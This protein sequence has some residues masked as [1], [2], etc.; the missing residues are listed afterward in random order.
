[1]SSIDL[2]MEQ[3]LLESNTSLFLR[4]LFI[5][6][7]LRN[8]EYRTSFYKCPKRES[9]IHWGH[10]SLTV[11]KKYFSLQTSLKPKDGCNSDQTYWSV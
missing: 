2:E 7:S 9:S 8:S 10:E 6:R 11:A 4:T 3:I 1:M 5:F